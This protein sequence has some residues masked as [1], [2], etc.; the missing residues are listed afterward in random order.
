M[1]Q[2]WQA[3]LKMIVRIAFSYNHYSL[4]QFSIYLGNII[5]HTLGT[6]ATKI[7]Y[8]QINSCCCVHLFEAY[9]TTFL[10]SNCLIVK[11]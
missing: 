2:P 1:D 9:C 3:Y 8:S 11:F 6:M 7:V 10:R 5:S 4:A